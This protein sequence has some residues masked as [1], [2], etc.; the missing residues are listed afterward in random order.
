MKT[1]QGVTPLDLKDELCH[2]YTQCV[3]CAKIQHSDFCTPENR[4]YEVQLDL[5]LNR[6]IDLIFSI[7]YQ[8]ITQLSAWMRTK[9]VV[10]KFVNATSSW[11]KISKT[12]R[13]FITT[14]FGPFLGLTGKKPA[15]CRRTIIQKI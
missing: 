6:L 15:E 7:L 4:V 1:F 10:E 3:K 2:K 12:F 8:K 9:L 11:S 13:I 5:L 14:I